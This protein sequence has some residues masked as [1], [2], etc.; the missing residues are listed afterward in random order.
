VVQG[1]LLSRPV[2]AEELRRRMTSRDGHTELV[3][4]VA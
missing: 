2:A 3:E 4:A 1:F